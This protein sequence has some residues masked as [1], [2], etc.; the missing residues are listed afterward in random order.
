MKWIKIGSVLLFPKFLW[1]EEPVEKTVEAQE[2]VNEVEAVKLS[3][4][5]KTNNPFVPYKNSENSVGYEASYNSDFEFYSVAEY[6]DYQEFSL[7]EKGA[8]KGFWLSSK[9][10]E[11]GLKRGIKYWNFYPNDHLLVIQ[12][13]SSGELINITQQQP[14]ISESKSFDAI[15]SNTN[16]DFLRLLTNQEDA[17]D[18]KEQ[19]GER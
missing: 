4:N 6:A 7:K 19:G 16:E 13:I 8:D 3:E 11:E 9:D 18:D 10:N 17:D 12:N 2:M 5:L 15:S 14:V 1:A